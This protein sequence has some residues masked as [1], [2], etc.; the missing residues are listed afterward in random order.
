MK[1][2]FH[3]ILIYILLSILIL[4]EGCKLFNEGNDEPNNGNKSS[5]ENSISSEYWGTWIRMDT[6]DEYYIDSSS[7]KK[8]AKYSYYSDSEVSR[9]TNGYSFDGENILKNGNIIYFRKGGKFRDFSV[10]VAGFTDTQAG[11]SRSIDI[12]RNGIPGRRKNKKNNNDT[13]TITS[14]PDGTLNFKNAVADDTHEITVADT[15]S[16]DIKPNYNGEDLGTIPIVEAGTYGFKTTYTIDGD[17][18][19]FCYGNYF[20]TYNLKLNINNIGSKI[21]STSVYSISYSDNNLNI[22]S[23]NLTGNFSSIEAGKSKEVSL[24]IR[25]GKLNEEYTDVPIKISITDSVYNRTWEDSVSIR[26]Y[27]GIVYLKVNSRNFDESSSATLNGFLIYP[28]GR[29]KRFTVASK[30]DS[31]VQVPWSNSDYHLAFSGATTEN[32]MAYS[33]GFADK[34]NLA[35]LSGTWSIGEINAYE[36]NDSI[37]NAYRVTDLSNP[38]KAYLKYGDIDFYTINCK[39]IELQFKPVSIIDK[40]IKECENGNNDNL[41]TPGESLYLDVKMKNSTNS[42]LSG[43]SLKLSTSSSYVNIIRDSYLLGDMKS[44]YYYSLTDY[45]SYNESSCYLMSSN[46]S[47]RTFK[48]SIASNCPSG[49]LLPFTVT[50]T[51]AS[52]YT[53]SDSF[54]I[55]VYTSQANIAL[56]SGTKYSV[57]EY[58]NGNNNNLV[59]PG[60]S[61]YLDI[62]AENKG[63]ST[64]LGVTVNL[65][66]NSNYVTLIRNSYNLGD[67][68]TGYYY[69]LTDYSSYNESSCY[70]MSSNYSTKAF[71]FTVSNACPAGTNLPFTVS[72]ADSS[73]NI[74]TDTLSIP[75]N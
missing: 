41:A 51:D 1:I 34:A 10:K 75:V 11:S 21:C 37:S 12:G 27:K 44:G 69:S 36:S 48:F 43:V 55:T 74:W 70:L 47:D 13:E 5:S 19:G 73:G 32:E 53:W 14:A 24:S 49:A 23:G 29:S 17:G 26:F 57:K 8:K 46:Y 16:V 64:A 67:M 50:F 45:S 66:T 42:T 25:Y 28:D 62:K 60:E 61:L 7:I 20:K 30:S 71:Q 4:V 33:F 65:L 18:Q 9:N 59:N 3:H 72:F 63:K 35:D 38:I 15:T 22:I 39:D 52:G 56:V 6:G 31:S 2:K 58:E 68:K 40:S 54:N